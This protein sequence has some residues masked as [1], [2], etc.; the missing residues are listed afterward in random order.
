MRTLALLLYYTMGVCWPT[1]AFPA[2]RAWNALRCFLVGR[3]LARF[4]RDNHWGRGVYLG[5][6]SDVQVGSNCH[7][8]D[9]CRL[10]NVQMGDFVMVGPEVVFLAQ[11]H[12]SDSTEVP[13]VLQGAVR[14]PPTIVEDD[15]WIGLRAIIMPGLRI[16]RGAIVGAGAVVTRD[17][18]P[19]AVVAGVP[20][21][22][23]RSRKEKP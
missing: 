4:G 22:L 3:I 20:A 16:G 7:V 9:G 14:Y 19:Y 6:G 10:V 17:V 23:L 1:L 13:M 8:N 11:V 5:D 18:P 21:R 15:V 12:R 2:G